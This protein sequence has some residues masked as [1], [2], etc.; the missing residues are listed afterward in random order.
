MPV[1]NCPRCF[2]T[3]WMQQD[4]GGIPA[5]TRCPCDQEV[6]AARFASRSGIPPLYANASTENFQLPSDN[7]VAHRG[8]A[9]AML[10]V[11]TY[12]R[13]YP[14]VDKPGLLFIGNTGVGKTHLATA[15]LRALIE[16]G[17]EGIFYD[18]QNLL[19]RIRSG[20]DKTSGA[21]D[22]EA[23]RRAL[24]IE[25]LLLDDLGAHRV[26]DWVEDTVTSILT[27]RC[28]S[29]KPTIVTTNLPPPGQVSNASKDSLA[30]RIGMRAW[31][32]LNEMCR[33]VTMPSVEDYRIRSRR[34]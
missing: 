20:Y 32:R 7:P 34:T 33:I 25:I 1:E 6:R 9:S 11:R 3:G 17:F 12:A 24:E 4:S 31:S 10:A 8:L 26:T 16:R 30:D 28:N 13:D 14:A 21:T 15:A 18:Y 5:V 19:D 29:L 27:H 22:R 23:Y 2:G